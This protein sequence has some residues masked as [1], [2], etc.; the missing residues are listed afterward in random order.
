MPFIISA[1]L[2]AEKEKD[3]LKRKEKEKDKE[4]ANKIKKES[5]AVSKLLNVSF[6]GNSSV[7]SLIDAGL[8]MIFK[9]AMSENKTKKV[10]TFALYVPLLPSD[11][12]RKRFCLPFHVH[13][14]SHLAF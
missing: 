3:K 10:V 13:V 1:L 4:E 5:S 6:D 2:G 12:T 11:V 9:V 7:D 14:Y 8:L